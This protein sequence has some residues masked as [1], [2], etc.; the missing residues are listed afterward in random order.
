MAETGL[1][2]SRLSSSTS[3]SWSLADQI[4]Q[5]QQQAAALGGAHAAPRAVEGRARRADGDIDILGIG[6]GDLR[7]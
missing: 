2:E 6:L 1:P 7:R 4:G 5:L 3:S